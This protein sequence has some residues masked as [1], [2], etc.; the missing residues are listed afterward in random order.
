MRVLY[1]L[2]LV[3]I[4][5]WRQS[6]TEWRRG[7]WSAPTEPRLDHQGSR[8]R[9][10]FLCT[11]FVSSWPVE[12]PVQLADEPTLRSWGGQDRV[13]VLFRSSIRYSYR[14]ITDSLLALCLKIQPAKNYCLALHARQKIS[15]GLNEGQEIYARTL[16]GEWRPSAKAL[17]PSAMHFRSMARSS[18]GIQ[19]ETTFRSFGRS[20]ADRR[21][22]LVQ[23]RAERC[24]LLLS[25]LTTTSTAKIMNRRWQT[26]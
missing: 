21:V 4:N 6:W 2:T 22:H 18:F 26:N 23:R 19:S 14:C 7:I 20:H 3:S 12:K 5:G 9:L 15:H 11:S 24:T 16:W 25:T 8:I 17:Q 1:R 13:F 10:A